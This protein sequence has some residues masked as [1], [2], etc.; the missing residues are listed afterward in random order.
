MF[1]YVFVFLIY[2]IYFVN[3]FFLQNIHK[4]YILCVCVVL[5]VAVFVL[6]FCLEAFWPQ[7]CML[8]ALAYVPGPLALRLRMLLMYVAR[9]G[10]DIRS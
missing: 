8:N 4:Y 6:W 5:L 2:I 7:R 9:G 3:H 1:L 10:E